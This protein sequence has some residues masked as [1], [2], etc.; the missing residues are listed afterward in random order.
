MGSGGEAA[1]AG[2]AVVAGVV[3]DPP[4]AADAVGQRASAMPSATQ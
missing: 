2:A 3:G 1:E 4:R